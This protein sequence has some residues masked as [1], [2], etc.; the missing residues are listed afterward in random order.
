M[1]K[2]AARPP[3]SAY[4]W[5]CSYS[6]STWPALDRGLAPSPGPPRAWL[7][8]RSR[9]PG[10]VTPRWVCGGFGSKFLLHRKRPPGRLHGHS[11]CGTRPAP[12]RDPRGPAAVAPHLPGASCSAWLQT[13]VCTSR[14]PGQAASSSAPHPVGGAGCGLRAAVAW[15]DR[16]EAESPDAA[17]PHEQLVE[18]PEEPQR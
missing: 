17:R 13:K 5:D 16:Q 4:R 14:P 8:F 2:I 1:Y 11:A 10:A 9:R 12:S 3:H 15:V 18:R 6:G 7:S